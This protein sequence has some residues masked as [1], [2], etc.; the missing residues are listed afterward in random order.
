M[1]ASDTTL[2]RET[3][4][5][6]RRKYWLKHATRVSKAVIAELGDQV[7]VNTLQWR[8]ATEFGL[9]AI[10]RIRLKTQLPLAVDAYEDNRAT[11]SFILIDEATNNTVA[12]GLIARA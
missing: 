5:D 12:A 4:L 6:P 9:N 11:G 3:P 7:D 10:G 8:A 2:R 1:A